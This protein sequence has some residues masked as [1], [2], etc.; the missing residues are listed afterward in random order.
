MAVTATVLDACSVAYIP[1]DGISN[2]RIEVKCSQAKHEFEAAEPEITSIELSPQERRLSNVLS[3]PGRRYLGQM[4]DMLIAWG[5]FL[6]SFAFVEWL[7]V[8]KEYIGGYALIPACVYFVFSDGFANGQSLG[9]K[10]LGMSVIDRRS[11]HYCTYWQSLLRNILTPVL[12]VLDAVFILSKRRQ[13]IGDKLARTIV[14]NR[15]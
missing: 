9:K 11:G 13:R 3:S 8:S 10:M 2:V 7:P 15:A 4:I 12:G 1:Q 14:V 5:I 6:A